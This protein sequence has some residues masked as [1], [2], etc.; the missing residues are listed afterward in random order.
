MIRSTSLFLASLCAVPLWAQVELDRPLTLT[1]PDASDRQVLGL[2][3]S[4]DP[5]AVLTTSL[6]QSNAYRNATPVVGE[7]WS[8]SLGSLSG[9]PPAG[10][11]LIITAPSSSSGAIELLVNGNGPYPVLNGPN[12]PLLGE[13]VPSGTLLSVVS[14]GSA[15]HVLNG[16]VAPRRPCPSG[17]VMVNQHYCIEQGKRPV[18][19]FFTAIDT[20]SALGLRLCG[21]SEFLIACQR[22]AELGLAQPT[23]SWECTNGASNE[24]NCARNVGAG[25]C[26]SAGNAFITGS[27]NRQYRCCYSR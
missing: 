1:G 4:S 6:A 18:A 26:L 25:S 10:T 23:N 9:P 22:A 14:D 2:P 27:T 8:V 3:T 7:G 21:W 11:H 15:F 16:H 17:T 24:N 12:E 13:D 20:C 19:D 5:D